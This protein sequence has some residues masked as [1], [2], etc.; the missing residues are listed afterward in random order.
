MKN[1][2]TG[3]TAQVLQFPKTSSLQNT[4]DRYST[5]KLSYFECIK[6]IENIIMSH[7]RVLDTPRNRY[8]LSGTINFFINTTEKQQRDPAG[9][10]DRLAQIKIFAGNEIELPEKEA[11]LLMSTYNKMVDNFDWAEIA[12]ERLEEE[13][14]KYFGVSIH[15]VGADWIDIDIR[16]RYKI[17]VHT[18]EVIAKR[19]GVTPL[20]ILDELKI[21]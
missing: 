20:S 21:R 15:E 10:L 2:N 11:E 3:T 6:H 18:L 7:S 5:Y 12:F 1:N 8:E 17:T 19:A 14:K 9:F 16:N 4:L 13:Y